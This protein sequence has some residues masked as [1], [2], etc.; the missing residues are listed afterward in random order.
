MVTN[1]RALG[2]EIPE[3]Y[4]VKKFLVGVPSKFLQIASTLEQFGNLDTM[5]FEETIGSLKPMK[6]G[7]KDK[8]KTVVDSCS[9]LKRNGQRK[10]EKG[11]NYC[12]LRKNG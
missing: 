3:A 8:V 4:V 10:N 9:L 5:T 11:G 7:Y 1:I 12:S 6:N 2:E